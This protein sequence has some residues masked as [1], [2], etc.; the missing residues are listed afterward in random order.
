[1]YDCIVYNFVT[2]LKYKIEDFKI[3]FI[4]KFFKYVILIWITK[5]QIKSV[6]RKKNVFSMY[7]KVTR[8]LVWQNLSHNYCESTD[9]E[10]TPSKDE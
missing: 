7:L 5:K 6:K 10:T 4:G 9:C 3:Y 8:L 1:M 2:G